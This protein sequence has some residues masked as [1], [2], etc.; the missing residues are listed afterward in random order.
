MM[1]ELIRGRGHHVFRRLRRGEVLAR[2]SGREFCVTYHRR[3]EVRRAF[4]PWFVL[5]Q[6]IGFGITVPPSAAEPWISKH[7]RLLSAMEAIDKPL[8]RPLAFF[9]DHVL[10]KFRRTGAQ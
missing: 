1:T 4:A 10:Y 8:S 3:A 7:P 5:E 2:L 9:G 6:R